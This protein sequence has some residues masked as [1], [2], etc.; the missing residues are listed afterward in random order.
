[1]VEGT[2]EVLDDDSGGFLGN[3]LCQLSV[4]LGA[5]AAHVTTQGLI[6]LDDNVQAGAEL[7]D[8]DI[9]ANVTVADGADFS[10]DH[11]PCRMGDLA[12]THSFQACT[13][14]I[15]RHCGAIEGTRLSRLNCLDNI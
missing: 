8:S 3:A 7:N 15:G 4:F 13:S 11:D 2:T 5:V 1:M 10:D 14:S 6:I 12:P 9:V